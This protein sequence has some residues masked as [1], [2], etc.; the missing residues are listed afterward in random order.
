M[1]TLRHLAA[2]CTALIL[3]FGVRG[4]YSAKSPTQEDHLAS[5]LAQDMFRVVHIIFQDAG[6]MH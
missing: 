1:A 4:D 3:G 5:G 6:S 2:F